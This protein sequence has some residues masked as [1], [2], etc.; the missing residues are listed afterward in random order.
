M[1]Y[2]TIYKFVWIL[3]IIFALH[4]MEEYLF[5][6]LMREV[7]DNKVG[8]GFYEPNVFLIAI[9]LLT[10]FVTIIVILYY[11]YKTR[12]LE[13]LIMLA[14]AIIFANGIMHTISSI[15]F[16]KYMPGVVTSV[17]LILPYSIWMISLLK[18]REGLQLK[19]GL[20]FFII[21]WILM[22]PIIVLSLL[23]AKGISALF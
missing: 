1:V 14:L 9:V 5:L 21:S 20:L 4:N 8:K 19:K 3:P 10:V 7:L 2:K 13:R 11:F 15:I 18:I 17:L 12:L 6:P 16:L 22:Y 23:T